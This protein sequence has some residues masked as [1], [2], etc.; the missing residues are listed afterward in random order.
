MRGGLRIAV[1]HVLQLMDHSQVTRIVDSGLRTAYR[2]LRIA[3]CGSRIT[4]RGLYIQ[5]CTS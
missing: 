4:D 1:D 5:D 3:D 2:G